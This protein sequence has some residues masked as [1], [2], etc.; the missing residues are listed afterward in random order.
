MCVEL[1]Q[2]RYTPRISTHGSRPHWGPTETEH[3]TSHF[4]PGY[5]SGQT[6]A[7]SKFVLVYPS[8]QVY[9]ILH[10]ILWESI[11]SL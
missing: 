1:P 11:M 4:Y 8:V 10:I 5:I 6:Q 3:D 9:T 2:K 7:K